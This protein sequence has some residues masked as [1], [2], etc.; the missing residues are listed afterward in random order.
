M[1]KKN[2][3]LSEVHTLIG[4]GPV[5]LVSTAFRCRPNVMTV[6]WHT[7]IDFEPPLVGCVIGAGSYT[8]RVLR[9]TRECVINVPDARLLKKAVACG[10]VSGHETDKFERF[11]L[12][13]VP[14]SRVK[15]PR[16]GECFANLECRVIDTNLA[17]RYDLFVMKVVQAWI[18]PAKKDAS[19][20]HHCGGGVFRISG[21][22]VRTA[23]RMK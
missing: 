22:T 18:D 16:V 21:R 6:S 1:N 3:P 4:R 10:N 9:S 7:M 19:T 13:A 20:I 14:S 15:A 23:S 17:D 5:I 11:G 12:T 8:A 2:F